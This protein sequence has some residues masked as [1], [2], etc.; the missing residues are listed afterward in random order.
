VPDVTTDFETLAKAVDQAA[1]AVEA[2]PEGA[3]KE[4][5][6]ELKDAI[7]AAHKAGLVTIVQKL[8]GDE[9]GKKLLFELVDDP[10]V[11]MLFAAHKII[12][13]APPDGTSSNG[14]AKGGTGD[15]AA[16]RLGGHGH[17][18]GVP[19]QSGPALIPLRAVRRRDPVED[20]LE[21]DG[22][23]RTIPAKGIPQGE[24][25]QVRVGDEDVILV[26]AR[27]ELTAYENRCAHEEMPLSD[28]LVDT[29]A[30]TVMCPWHG[31]R[32]DSTTGECLTE[33]GMGLSKRDVKIVGRDVWI[34]GGD[35]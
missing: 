8:K 34:R 15:L 2:L 20:E 1:E 4:A 21:A 32:Y 5:A 35:R 10:V 3:A 28:A 11:R 18:H 6:T 9:A 22:W 12:R 7:E 29:M 16:E 24:A 31:Y 19:A 30:C 23:F 33:A 25:T 14:G 13:T 17:D 27:D 26:W